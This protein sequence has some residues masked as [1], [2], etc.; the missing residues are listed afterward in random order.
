MNSFAL[1][2]QQSPYLPNQRMT[3]NQ[4]DLS[5]MSANNSLIMM[6]GENSSSTR[7]NT[8][9]PVSGIQAKVNT[10]KKAISNFQHP[11]V[12]KNSKYPEVFKQNSSNSITK[13]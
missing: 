10:D 5:E 13:D 8:T 3:A 2:D 1:K 11:K 6:N 4:P 7:P 9:N 12:G